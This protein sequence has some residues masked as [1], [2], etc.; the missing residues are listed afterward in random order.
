V[1]QYSLE[2][3]ALKR[4]GLNYVKGAKGKVPPNPV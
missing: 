4:R 1:I 3:T 2:N